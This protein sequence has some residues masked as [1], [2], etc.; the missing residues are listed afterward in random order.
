M[1]EERRS[2]FLKRWAETLRR[3]RFLPQ[4]N[5][6]NFERAALRL[7]PHPR[8]LVIVDA[9]TAEVEA[10]LQSNIGHRTLYVLHGTRVLMK[11]LVAKTDMNVA[12]AYGKQR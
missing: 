4:E 11:R 5:V 1:I 10:E 9:G 6:L 12:L 8:R 3:Q 2:L 7:L